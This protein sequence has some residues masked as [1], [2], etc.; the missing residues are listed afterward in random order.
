MI[1]CGIG[2]PDSGYRRGPVAPISRRAQACDSAARVCEEMTCRSRRGQLHG[3][4]LTILH[5]H[6]AIAAF[7]ADVAAIES[8]GIDRAALARVAARMAHA[9]I[10]L[11]AHEVTVLRTLAAFAAGRAP[12]PRASMLKVVGAQVRQRLTDLI[13]EALSPAGMR[14]EPAMLDGQAEEAAAA[15]QMAHWLYSRAA[16]IYGGSN[17]IQKNIL[18]KAVL[19]L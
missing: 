18:A 15:A 8:G 7:I 13:V 17:E 6:P 12:G 5:P 3:V 11:I 1:A 14:Y 9:E 2:L 10:D 19:G 16:S 4:L